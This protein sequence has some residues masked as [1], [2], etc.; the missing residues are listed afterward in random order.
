MA[1]GMVVRPYTCYGRGGHNNANQSGI[2]VVT[3]ATG[4][5]SS[6]PQGQPTNRIGDINP[7]D[8]ASIEVLKGASA[9]AMYG[10][11][12]S[13]GVIII[14]TKQGQGGKTVFSFSQRIGQS[15][16]VNKM[17]HRVFAN[18]AEAE[19]QYG[20]AIADLG[21]NASGSWANRDIDYEQETYGETGTLKE[22]VISAAGGN[23]N[24]QFY[25]GGQFLDE[26][27]IIN[28]TG[29]KKL[30]G[31]LNMKHRFS[32]KTRV[33][34]TTNLSRTESDRGVTGNDN[35]GLTYLTYETF[36]NLLEPIG[37]RPWQTG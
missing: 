35:S 5:G 13:N 3:A 23:Q 24:T 22:T 30:S 12:A 28:N 16:L 25:F 7:N 18:Y 10:A 4:A 11:K 6:T 36:D 34:L 8:I 21:N 31:R 9:A 33:S 2:D 37:R 19:E 32:D 17:G 14:K 27:G 20:S 26:G 15:K 1:L 29:Y